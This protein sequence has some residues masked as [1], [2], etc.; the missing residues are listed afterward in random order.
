[1]A[2]DNTDDPV[3]RQKAITPQFLRKLHLL[4]SNP[5]VEANL[6]DHAVDLIIGAYFFAMRS[7]EYVRPTKPGKTKT[8]LLRH[9]VFRD[10]RKKI[11]PHTDPKLAAKME[12]CTVCFEDQKNGMKQDSRTQR[13]TRDPLLCPSR[14]A[15]AVRRVVTTVPNWSADTHLCSLHLNHNTHTISQAFTL[16]LLRHTCKTFGGRE[17]FGFDAHEIGNKSLRSGA[18][19]ALFLKNHSVA[20]IMILGRWSSDAFLVYIR[21]QVLEWANNMSTDMTNFDSFLDVG[22]HD[23]ASKSDPMTSRRRVTL[24]GRSSPST[25][26]IPAFDLHN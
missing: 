20:K 7:C 11:I 19:M 3:N 13:R 18:A 24:N 22:M 23:I 14:L 17:T 5:R 10:W 1:M 16:K 4:G 25:V 2:F 15:R 26:I 9:L 6:H 21:P 12:Y 8:L